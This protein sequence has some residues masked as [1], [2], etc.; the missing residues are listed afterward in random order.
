MKPALVRV[1]DLTVRFEARERVVHAV[2]GVDLA[3]GEGA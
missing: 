1:E 2:N 3:L